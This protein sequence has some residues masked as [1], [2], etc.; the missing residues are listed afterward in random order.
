[1]SA[2]SLDFRLRDQ[3]VTSYS[4]WLLKR[5]KFRSV[6]NKDGDKVVSNSSIWPLTDQFYVNVADMS[7]Q[8]KEPSSKTFEVKESSCTQP[9]YLTI[10]GSSSVSPLKRIKL[11]NVYRVRYNPFPRSQK[12]PNLIH[13]S[14]QTLQLVKC[15]NFSCDVNVR[16]SCI[17][18]Y[19]GSSSE[20]YDTEPGECLKDW[21][22]DEVIK[23]Y[24]TLSNC[25]Q[26]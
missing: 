5:I 21:V 12:L 4:I 19:N 16:G 8:S 1:M 26:L 13:Q 24:P 7:E 10:Y 6:W 14:A 9:E 22:S 2:Q 20:A 23:L 11:R 15:S 18:H 25:F 17:G 3:V